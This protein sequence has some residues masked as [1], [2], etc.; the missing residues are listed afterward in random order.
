MKMEA[1]LRRLT[2]NL[3]RLLV[4]KFA[5]G[6]IGV[7][8]LPL[9]TGGEIIIPWEYHKLGKFKDAQLIDDAGNLYRVRSYRIR[10]LPSLRVLGCSLTDYII[11]TILGLV[12]LDPTIVVEPDLEL[13]ETWDL[14]RVKKFVDQLIADNADVYDREPD[15]DDESPPRTALRVRQLVAECNSVGAIS[16]ALTGNPA[17][18]AWK[19]QERDT[20]AAMARVSIGAWTWTIGILFLAIFIGPL[21]KTTPN[22]FAFLLV[23]FGYLGFLRWVVHRLRKA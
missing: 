17:P 10:G 5:S 20:A 19:E 3:P 21:D 16:A 15:S 14:A 18:N 11:Q 4:M 9:G 22:A 6:R 1:D 7:N 12:F 2:A 8:P 23:V 13:V